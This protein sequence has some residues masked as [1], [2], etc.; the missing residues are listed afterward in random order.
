M[1]KPALTLLSRNEIK[2]VHE[3]SLEILSEIGVKIEDE[4]VVN[5]LKS[6]GLDVEGKVVKIPAYMVKEALAKTP[7]TITLYG[8]NGKPYHVLGEGKTLFNPGSAAIKILDYGSTEPRPPI[9][10]DLR[11]LVIVVD[12]LENIKAQSTALVPSDIPIEASDLVRLYPVLKYSE[13]PIITGAFSI[14]GLHYMVKALSIVIN[15]LDKKPLAIFDVCPS[16]PLK[17]SRIAIRNLVDGAKY[18]V[19]LE[20]IPMPQIGATGPVTIAGS[21]IQHNAEILSGIV[22]AQLASPGTPIIYGGSPSTFEMRYGTSLIAGI[23]ALLLVTAYVDMAK[24]YGI[25]VHGYLGLSDS[26]QIDYQAGLETML[27]ALIAT[28]KGV[29]VASG[30]GMLEFESVQSLE[31]LVLDDEICGLAFRYAKGFEI[32]KDTLATDVIRKVRH[33]GHFLAQKHTVKY[34][35]RELYMPKI[36][37]RAGRGTAIKSIIQKA[38]EEV[39]RILKE[40][41]APIL[42]KDIEKELVEYINS[43]TLKYGCNLNT[44]ISKYRI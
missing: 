18:H 19:P 13:K 9:L 5:M 17:W 2:T 11:N 6:K 10:K 34:L 14:E 31:K 15:D 40:H 41:K 42:D 7:R 26:K 33:G 16:P 38:R 44:I 22:I 30:P 20:I 24:Y 27:G 37:D 35:R 25:P 1:P 8:R 23:E 4:N 3:C 21:L 43:V 29:D 12:A 36:L 28:I 32:S 39:I